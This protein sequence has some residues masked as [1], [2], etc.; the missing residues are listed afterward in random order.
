MGE[1][2]MSIVPYRIRKLLRSAHQRYTFRR[3]MKEY[4]NSPESCADP[5]SPVLSGLI[6]GWG[7]YD[8]SAPKNYLARCIALGLSSASPSVECGSGLSTIIMGVVAQKTRCEHWALEHNSEWGGRVQ[9]ELS[10]YGLDFV[11]LCTKP[12]KD[13][14]E[15]CWYDAPL[16]DM[17]KDFGLAM[18]DGPPGKTKG[19]RYGFLPVMQALLAPHCLVLLDDAFREDERSIVTRWEGEFGVRVNNAT[20]GEFVELAMPRTSLRGT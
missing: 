15:F 19:G 18:C 9:S 20:V 5:N 11:R 3:A 13:Y 2:L 14:G 6:Y 16:S 1:Q 12:L 7:N 4:L 17:P 10:R 8:W